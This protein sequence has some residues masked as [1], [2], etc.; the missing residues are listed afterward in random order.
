MKQYGVHLINTIMHFSC[1]CR[2]RRDLE[3]PVFIQ[4]QKINNPHLALVWPCLQDGRKRKKTKKKKGIIIGPQRYA[5][6]KNGHSCRKPDAVTP[7]TAQTGSDSVLDSKNDISSVIESLNTLSIGFQ[8]QKQHPS[9]GKG[10]QLVFIVRE[11]Q[12][13]ADGIK[14]DDNR[15]KH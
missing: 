14:L 4:I 3:P 1:T 6:G 12:L 8:M 15:L 10:N 11:L 13:G 9:V 2:R 5:F 7:S